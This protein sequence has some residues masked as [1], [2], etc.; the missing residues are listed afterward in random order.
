M[1]DSYLDIQLNFNET[2]ANVNATGA[3]PPE[4]V[5]V[6]L[7]N[8]N[9]TT[10]TVQNVMELAAD[11]SNRYKFTV[12]YTDKTTGYTIDVLSGLEQAEDC[13]WYLFYRAPGKEEPSYQEGARISFFV[14]QPNS[15]VV[16]SY[17]P[18]QTVPPEPSPTPTPVT[19]DNDNNNNGAPSA[20][21][22]GSFMMY[23]LVLVLVSLF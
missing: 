9:S 12:T 3:T 13:E 18:E 16:L 5:S 15:T 6:L 19:P 23:C 11:T 4:P 21:Q 20:Y 14:V 1:Q 7:E 22:M 10:Y 17:E 2:C 8:A